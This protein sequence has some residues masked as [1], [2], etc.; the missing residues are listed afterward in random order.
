MPTEKHREAA[1]EALP[2]AWDCVSI[3]RTQ[4]MCQV[5]KHHPAIAAVLERAVLDEREAIAK[6]AKAWSD[7]YRR[8]DHDRAAISAL[9]DFANVIHAGTEESDAE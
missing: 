1:R 8:G 7:E 2:C 6:L 9:L 5:C 3:G 4:A